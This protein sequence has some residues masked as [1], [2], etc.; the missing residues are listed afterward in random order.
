MDQDMEG[1]ANDTDLL[2]GYLSEDELIEELAKAGVKSSRTS[3]RRWRRLRTGPP[4]VR[5]SRQVL[6]PREGVTS[7]LRSLEDGP[8][9]RGF[10][11]RSGRQRARRGAGR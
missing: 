2:A 7:W 1:D 4:W 11:N 6:Y 5:V 3:L 8:V 10:T 9:N